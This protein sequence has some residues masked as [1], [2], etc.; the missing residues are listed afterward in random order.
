VLARLKDRQLAALER[1]L[2]AG[3][4]LLLLTEGPVPDQAFALIARAAQEG[5]A[6]APVRDAHQ[7]LAAAGE[8]PSLLYA[9]LGRLAVAP[10][11]QALD[12]GD[13]WRQ[14]PV[15]L[16]NIRCDQAAEMVANGAWNRAL[17]EQT[18]STNA[19]NTYDQYDRTVSFAHH[20]LSINGPMTNVLMP[21]QIAIIPFSIVLI[22]FVVFILIIGPGDWLVLG[23]LRARRFTWIVFPL[24]AIS[25]TV[26]MVRMSRHYLGG[27]D[28]RQH[29]EIVDFGSEGAV[30]RDERI[31]LVFTGNSTDLAS[32]I[33]DG[34]WAD[35]NRTGQGGS[36]PYSYQRYRQQ[37]TS[38]VNSTP[39]YDGA[40]PGSYRVTQAVGQWDPR[41]RRS[42]SFSAPADMPLKISRDFTDP[43]H[44]A[45][46]ASELVGGDA[47]GFV[48]YFQGG[49]LTS[50]LGQIET[51]SGHQQVHQQW[52]G[53][54]QWIQ[55]LSCHVQTGWFAL[56][57]RTSPAGGSTWE[58][59]PV[60]DPTDKNQWLL[61]TAVHAGDS[62]WVARRLYRLHH[63]HPGVH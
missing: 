61:I 25:F 27:A 43:S 7:G 51:L 12:A 62:L 24:V 60:H 56:C 3:G 54:Q 20:D 58:D 34:L 47:D 55:P 53:N 14:L 18:H 31:E 8:H 29:L 21:S 23:W 28:H 36:N 46:A 49:Q 11:A 16:W 38:E 52:E 39:T 50:V 19:Q 32:D 17:L 40:V 26:F 13:A 35:L 5:G 22:T 10:L 15:H 1:W 59:I 45:A 4:S 41:L 63:D 44:V 9:G 6:P 33:H 30:L 48:G 2:R 37:Q 57:S 42:L